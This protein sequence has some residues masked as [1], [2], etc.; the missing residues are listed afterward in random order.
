MGHRVKPLI[1]RPRHLG[2]APRQGL[3]HRIDAAGGLALRAQHF[4]QAFF[5]FVGA[6]GLRDSQFRAAPAGSRDH[7]RN[8]E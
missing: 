7:D 2:L 4:A 3:P 8:D 6:N 5:K 1:D